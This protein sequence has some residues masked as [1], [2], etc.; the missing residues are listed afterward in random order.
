MS[1]EYEFKMRDIVLYQK[2]WSGVKAH[3]NYLKSE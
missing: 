3:F 2:V 1:V